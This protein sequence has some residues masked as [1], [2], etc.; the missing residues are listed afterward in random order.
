MASR[1]G[2]GRPELVGTEPA[3]RRRGLVRAQFEEIHRWSAERGEMV[4]G[5][6]GIPFYYRQFGYEMALNLSGG[7]RCYAANIPKLKEGEPETHRFRPVAEADLPFVLAVDQ[8]A[9][10]RSRLTCVR[11]LRLWRYEAFG[12]SE[13][14]GDRREMRIIETAAGEPLGVLA[15]G[16]FLENGLM[17]VSWIELKPGVS[18]L[19]II[20]PLLRFM[21]ATA[22]A[23][24]ARDGKPFEVLSFWMGPEHPLNQ[25]AQ[26]RLPHVRRPYAWYLR[27]PDLPA[28]LRHIAPALEARLAR[29]WAVGHTGDL[30][31]DFYRDGL[32]LVF[33]GGRL[34]A[35]EKW[36]A[37]RDDRGGAGF[38]G[39]TFL[40]LLFGYRTLGALRDAFA[41]CWVD[42]DEP[43]A[44]LEALFPQ[45]ASTLWPVM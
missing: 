19:P 20:P 33:E 38:P 10:P 23:Y 13:M 21:H 26:D 29:S 41:D 17:G 12:K 3:Y 32:R 31:L 43:R 28:F 24:A 22:E 8:A 15:H 14:N 2:F 7:R 6:T 45:Q 1:S 35:V 42:G 36:M 9:A 44:L 5:I 37:S 40:Q 34:T 16:A 4:Q 30:K 11:D 27:V 39:L 25:V 18:W